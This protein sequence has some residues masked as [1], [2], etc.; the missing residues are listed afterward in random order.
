MELIAAASDDEVNNP[1]SGFGRGPLGQM[2]FATRF[3]SGGPTPYHPCTPRPNSSTD[4][5]T[6]AAPGGTTT[7]PPIL[8]ASNRRGAQ[9]GA[10]QP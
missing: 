8:N 4:I 6:K 10:F 7:R 1:W 3:H 9:P 2:S 5:V